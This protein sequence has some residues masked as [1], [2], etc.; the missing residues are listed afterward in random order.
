MLTFASLKS[1]NLPE[2]A[3]TAANPF[4]RLAQAA[5]PISQ[6]RIVS[7]LRVIP[8]SGLAEASIP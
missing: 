3:A 8:M 5:T 1:P 7:F 2:W 4:D 6:E